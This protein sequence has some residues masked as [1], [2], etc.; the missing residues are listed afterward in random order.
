MNQN[1][2]ND[3]A[4]ARHFEAKAKRR[5]QD[6]R[7]ERRRKDSYVP[8]PKPPATPKTSKKHATTPAERRKPRAAAA[9]TERPVTRSRAAA[10]K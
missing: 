2:R 8:V 7:D 4:V 10:G 5:L 9:T 6:S 3:E 1:Q